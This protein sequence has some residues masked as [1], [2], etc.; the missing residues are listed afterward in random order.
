MYKKLPKFNQKIEKLYINQE[1]THLQFFEQEKDQ[2]FTPV[3]YLKIYKKIT[4]L[5]KFIK[6]L[7]N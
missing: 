4:N 5:S 6:L 1:P 3:L 2:D 7:K